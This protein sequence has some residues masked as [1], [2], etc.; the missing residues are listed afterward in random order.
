M[1]KEAQGSRCRV[2]QLPHWYLMFPVSFLLRKRRTVGGADR[3]KGDERCH[4]RAGPAIGSGRVESLG[5][6]PATV[7]NRNQGT[8]QAASAIKAALRE[9]RKEPSST[10]GRRRKEFTVTKSGIRPGLGIQNAAQFFLTN[11]K[12]QKLLHTWKT[13]L[14]R[15]LRTLVI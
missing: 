13:S 2:L 10:R 12:I 6:F 5:A 1:L 3:T 7:P 14:V 15:I 9:R 4:Q 8:S 11:S